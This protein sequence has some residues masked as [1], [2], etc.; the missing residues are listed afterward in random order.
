M[1]NV[2]GD[3]LQVE[4]GSNVVKMFT[5]KDKRG[6]LKKFFGQDPPPQAQLLIEYTKKFREVLA[7][8]NVYLPPIKYFD[9]SELGVNNF[10][11]YV[12]IE[13]Y[14]GD[15][16]K[17]NLFDILDFLIQRYQIEDKTK[18]GIMNIFDQGVHNLIARNYQNAVLDFSK[19]YYWSSLVDHCEQELV[20]A[21][22]NIA[23]IELLN[24]RIENA[25]LSVKRACVIVSKEYYHDPYLRC[26]T[27]NFRA[28]L[29]AKQNK[30]KDATEYYKLAYDSIKNT[31]DVPLSV[32]V[33]FNL[34]TMY[35]LAQQYQEAA[36]LIDYIVQVIK[37]NDSF[38]K[39]VL[40]DLYEF[41]VYL[42]NL[43][44]ASLEDKYQNLL[45]QYQDLSKNFILKAYDS[46]LA[47]IV[48]VGPYVVSTLVGAL[49]SG[50][51]TN[52]FNQ[53]NNSGT[54]TIYL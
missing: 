5:E 20:K 8:K 45:K 2:D 33:L 13:Y 7:E 14:E 54:N 29:L 23:G 18:A 47:V 40:A 39:G 35:L 28:N 25:E 3:L 48:K 49:I 19:V 36:D 34:A 17:D 22:L 52:N 24:Y 38:G 10:K 15:I 37:Y 30:I 12:G 21:T 53:M 4:V 27:Y 41:R 51:V 44:L 6:I 11:V 42:S 43:T 1:W 26:Y 50:D 9:S 16:T 32:N 46:A 31:A